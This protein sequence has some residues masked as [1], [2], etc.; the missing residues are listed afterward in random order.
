MEIVSEIVSSTTPTRSPQPSTSQSSA[1]PTID[2]CSNTF[3]ASSFE[4]GIAYALLTQEEDD[5]ELDPTPVYVP[6]MGD[7]V[8]FRTRAPVIRY[9]VNQGYIYISLNDMMLNFK[10]NTFSFFGLQ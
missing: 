5:T 10:F 1:T 3:L 8:K 9:G 2:P 4:Q 6:D 7:R